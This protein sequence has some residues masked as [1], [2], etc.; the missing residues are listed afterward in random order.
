MV[1]SFLISIWDVLGC[2]DFMVLNGSF[3]DW[4]N[5]LGETGWDCTQ[6]TRPATSTGPRK[7]ALL[8]KGSFLAFHA[9]LGEG[10]S[11]PQSEIR[12]GSVR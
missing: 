7:S 6:M 2:M 12:F 11:V 5:V 3:I 10:R 1:H 8:V 4:G 9:F